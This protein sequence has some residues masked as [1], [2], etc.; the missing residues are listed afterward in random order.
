MLKSITCNYVLT[1]CHISL[2][3]HFQIKQTQSIQLYMLTFGRL[4][5]PILHRTIF[6]ILFLIITIIEQPD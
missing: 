3:S 5:F 6:I 2:K 4:H 1:P